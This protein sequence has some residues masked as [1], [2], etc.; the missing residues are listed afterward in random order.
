M[1]VT[2]FNCLDCGYRVTN[3]DLKIECAKCGS[4]N[5]AIDFEPA[6]EGSPIFISNEENG[7]LN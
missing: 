7:F 6:E 2:E 3:R 5:T 1:A 4:V